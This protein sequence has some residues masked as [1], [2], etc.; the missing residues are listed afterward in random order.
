MDL[1][2]APKLASGDYAEVVKTLKKSMGDSMV[3]ARIGSRSATWRVKDAEIW[4]THDKCE[5]I[6]HWCSW[7]LK[8]PLRSKSVCTADPIAML[9]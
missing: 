5:R 4:C 7:M 8:R 1:A 3:R 9:A 2:K 6:V